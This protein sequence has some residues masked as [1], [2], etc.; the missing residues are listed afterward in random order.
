MVYNTVWIGNHQCNVPHISKKYFGTPCIKWMIVS[1]VSDQLS[2]II[3]VLELIFSDGLFSYKLQLQNAINRLRLYSNSL[4]HILSLSNS[5]N[6]VASIQKNRGDKS[7][8]VTA[9]IYKLAFSPDWSCCLTFMS[10]GLYAGKILAPNLISH[11]IMALLLRT[12]LI[13]NLGIKW[14]PDSDCA[15]KII[16]TKF[17]LSSTYGS[18]I[19]K[20]LNFAIFCKKH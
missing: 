12:S 8:G 13:V 10:R 11:T 2:D 16:L 18:I 6:N 20:G 5:H 17:Q 9:A 19:S 14:T 7:H 1:K 4:I 15:P 3:I